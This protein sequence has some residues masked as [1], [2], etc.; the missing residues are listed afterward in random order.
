MGPENACA[1]DCPTAASTRSEQ[2]TNTQQQFTTTRR[3]GRVVHLRCAEGGVPDWATRTRGIG[4]TIPFRACKPH[5]TAI[6]C[7]TRDCS[8]RKRHTSRAQARQRLNVREQ[9]QREHEEHVA[10]AVSR[11][12]SNPGGQ[13]KATTQQTKSKRWRGSPRQLRRVAHDARQ[14]GGGGARRLTSKSVCRTQRHQRWRA[15][16]ERRRPTR[17]TLRSCRISRHFA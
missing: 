9:A 10:A 1:T 7:L 15:G 6:K 14:R 3:K 16:C 8:L 12:A 11:Q 13:R 2:G 17:Q 4:R 5:E